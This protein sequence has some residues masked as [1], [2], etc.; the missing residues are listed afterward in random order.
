MPR[1]RQ[2]TMGKVTPEEA[3]EAAIKLNLKK[4]KPYRLIAKHS[5]GMTTHREWMVILNA[6]DLAKPLV[7]LDGISSAKK[8]RKWLKLLSRAWAEGFYASGSTPTTGGTD[9]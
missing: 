1:Q 6:D 7:V 8:G 9:G 3:H 4:R 5:F 2:I